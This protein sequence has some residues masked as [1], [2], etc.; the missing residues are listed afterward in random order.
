MTLSLSRF[1]ARA[2]FLKAG[3]ASVLAVAV[4]SP[5]ASIAAGNGYYAT[6]AT[7]PADKIMA[8][9]TVFVCKGADCAAR[10]SSSSPARVCAA[11][12]KEAGPVSAFSFAGKAFD[13]AKLAK[14]NAAAG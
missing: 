11:L 6:L 8:A 14:C 12:V 3:R 10:E 4:L 9:G 13:D 1:S 2:R 5:A 7:A